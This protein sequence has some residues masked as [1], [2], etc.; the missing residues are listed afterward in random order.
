MTRM[1]CVTVVAA[2]AGV[3]SVTTA[4]A[5]AT[6]FAKAQV[7][8]V[9]G[10][11]AGGNYYKVCAWGDAQHLVTAGGV[12]DL[13]VQ[14]QTATSANNYPTRQTGLAKFAAPGVCQYKFYRSGTA[15]GGVNAVLNYVDTD[16]DVVG[17]ASNNKPWAALLSADVNADGVLDD[18]VGT[19]LIPDQAGLSS[20]ESV[21]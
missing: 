15:S 12:W 17:T 6:V 10:R 21:R 3:L 19:Y 1:R 7:N 2:V 14:V 13:E 20:E 11:D 8:I 9:A 18:G 5:H 16:V 4:P